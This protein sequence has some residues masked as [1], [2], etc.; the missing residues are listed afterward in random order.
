MGY[1][2]SI[3]RAKDSKQTQGDRMEIAK[4]NGE[5]FDAS[6]AQMT[7]AGVLEGI[8]INAKL[9]MLSCLSIDGTQEQ[10]DRLR[11]YLKAEGIGLLCKD[12]ETEMIE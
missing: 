1:L 2:V 8:T 11:E 4:R 10:I 6:V 12:C 9:K 5:A 7:A 3:H